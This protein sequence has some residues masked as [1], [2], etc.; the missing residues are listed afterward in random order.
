[1]PEKL[2]KISKVEVEAD[3]K[4]E[5]KG[6]IHAILLILVGVFGTAINIVFGFLFVGI[7]FGLLLA[8]TLSQDKLWA[9]R[10]E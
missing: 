10:E 3:T 6:K 8:I 5:R 2:I 4:N 7:G 1:M 9:W